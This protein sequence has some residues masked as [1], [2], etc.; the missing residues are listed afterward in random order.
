M[1]HRWYYSIW[2][3]WRS[4]WLIGDR[5]TAWRLFSPLRAISAGVGG[6]DEETIRSLFIWF[7][8]PDMCISGLIII[9][10]TAFRASCYVS[11]FWTEFDFL[12]FHKTCSIMLERPTALD[13]CGRHLCV[14]IADVIS[15]KSK[16]DDHG[17]TPLFPLPPL[18][19]TIV[20]HPL[21]TSAFVDVAQ[22]MT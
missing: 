7:T 11:W 9:F 1:S 15:R 2:D 13:W 18:H 20:K 6:W 12:Q 22:A 19:S 10:W 3:N 5:L 16:A 21:I 4:S 14:K 17:L 8:F